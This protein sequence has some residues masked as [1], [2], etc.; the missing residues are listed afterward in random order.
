MSEG[1]KV[2]IGISLEK[3]YFE[4]ST[5]NKNPGRFLFGK[6]TVRALLSVTFYK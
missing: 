3:H 5:R 1:M 4:Q 2:K 6:K